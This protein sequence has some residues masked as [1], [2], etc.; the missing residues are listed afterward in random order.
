MAPFGNRVVAALLTGMGRDGAEGLL[1]IRQAGGWTIAQNEA[2]SVVFG[3][4]RVAQELGAVKERLP[5]RKISSAILAA[6]ED[7]KKGRVT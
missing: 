7:L 5:L 6:S 3:M 4:P 2:T 1:A